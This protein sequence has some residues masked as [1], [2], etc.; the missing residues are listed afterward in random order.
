MNQC[1]HLA[2]EVLSAALQVVTIT[3]LSTPNC[4][5]EIFL[6]LFIME[7]VFRNR[8]YLRV[9][10]LPVTCAYDF[11]LHARLVVSSPETI[12]FHIMPPMTLSKPY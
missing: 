10:F 11:F 4:G 12:S 6:K 7:S 8:L 9:V 2:I 1:K 5:Q 3:Y